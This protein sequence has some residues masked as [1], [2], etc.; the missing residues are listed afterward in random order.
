[1]TQET[2][3]EIG[4]YKLATTGTS[5]INESAKGIERGC[6]WDPTQPPGCDQY[7]GPGMVC[8]MVKTRLAKSA[9]LA[10]GLEAV[11]VKEYEAYKAREAAVPKPESKQES[12]TLQEAMRLMQARLNELETKLAAVE[13]NKKT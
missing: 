13:G 10:G 12:K 11:T 8:K 4:Y 6:F 1:M 5:N 7:L 9:F 2:E 3:T